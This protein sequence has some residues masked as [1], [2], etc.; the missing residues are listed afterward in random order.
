[1][2]GTRAVAV[3]I[4]SLLSD[5]CYGTP[6]RMI[7]G[8]D[9]NRTSMLLAVAQNTFSLPLGAKDCFINVIG[10]MRITDPACDLALIASVVS[11]A[12]NIPLRRDT[13][14]LGEVGLTG[15]L[16]PVA[17]AVS[18]ISD[19]LRLG[20]RTAVLPGSCKK[21]LGKDSSLDGRCEIIFVDDLMQAMDVLFT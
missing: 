10:G 8:P 21:E 14:I 4:Q 13:L 9:R 16:R 11:A 3:E 12:R 19:A 15:E 7:N 5:T 2:E 20:I 17:G 1:M 18:R 6:Q